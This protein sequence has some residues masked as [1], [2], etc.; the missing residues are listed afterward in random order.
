MYAENG[1]MLIGRTLQPFKEDNGDVGK[2]TEGFLG[3]ML[4]S[5]K[6][7]KIAVDYSI[8]KASCYVSVSCRFFFK[9]QLQFSQNCCPAKMD[10]ITLVFFAGKL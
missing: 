2:S 9:L 6:T 10:L 8:Q 1:I 5:L 4:T 3:H 7:V